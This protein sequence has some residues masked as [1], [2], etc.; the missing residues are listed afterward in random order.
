MLYFSNYFLLIEGIWEELE[1]LDRKLK[2]EDVGEWGEQH[3][4]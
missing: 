1:I 2:G 4:L 3:K